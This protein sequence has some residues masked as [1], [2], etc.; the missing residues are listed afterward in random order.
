MCYDIFGENVKGVERRIRRGISK[1]TS[2]DIS[3]EDD[4]PLILQIEKLT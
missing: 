1:D 4:A 3:R 2:R